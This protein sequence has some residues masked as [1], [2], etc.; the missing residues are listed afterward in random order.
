VQREVRIGSRRTGEVE[1][2]EGLAEGEKVITHGA[3][4]VKAGQQ[5]RISAVDDGTR[6]LSEMLQS[7]G[8]S[9]AG[10]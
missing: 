7:T 2:V 3:L 8:K 10:Q 9:G 1:I 4:K 5:V 6:P